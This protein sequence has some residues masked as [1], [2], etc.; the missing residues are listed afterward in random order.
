[1]YEIRGG[2]SNY[3]RYYIDGSYLGTARDWDLGDIPWPDPFNWNEEQWTCGVRASS[4]G[5]TR[6]ARTGYLS[7]GTGHWQIRKNSNQ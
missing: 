5:A 2:D 1:M 4:T 7:G 6:W 3:Y